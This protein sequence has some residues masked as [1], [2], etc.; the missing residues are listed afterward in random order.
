MNDEQFKNIELMS[1]YPY[2]YVQVYGNKISYAK[3]ED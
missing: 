2:L 1:F 3:Y